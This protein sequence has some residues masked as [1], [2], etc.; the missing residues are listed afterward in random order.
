MGVVEQAQLER[1]VRLASL[2]GRLLER[3]LDLGGQVLAQ[4]LQLAVVAQVQEPCPTDDP[5][6][7]AR[8]VHRERKPALHVHLP[9]V[10]LDRN[11]PILRRRLVQ[12]LVFE[13]R[14]RRDLFDVAVLAVREL[15][16]QTV[17]ARERQPR[18]PVGRDEV[19]LDFLGFVL[20]FVCLFVFGRHER[21][22]HCEKGNSYRRRRLGLGVGGLSAHK[23]K[24]LITSSVPANKNKTRIP[25]QARVRQTAH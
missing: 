4:R 13:R 25:V 19:A 8:P 15:E 1:V 17:V 14:W 22:V 16:H 21:C 24:D 5:A 7:R 3:L 10:A 18:W 12:R 20:F 9:E 11:R 6:R 2:P 23:P